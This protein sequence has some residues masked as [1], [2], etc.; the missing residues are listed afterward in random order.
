MEPRDLYSS[1][2]DMRFIK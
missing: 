2:N 1:A